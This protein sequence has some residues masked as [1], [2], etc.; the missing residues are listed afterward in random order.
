VTGLDQIHNGISRFLSDGE[1]L[2]FN[3]NEPGHGVRCYVVSVNGGKATPITPEGITGGIVSPDGKFIVANDPVTLYPLAGGAPRSIPNL[4]PGFVPLQWTEDQSS[5]YVY[6][7]G[8]VPVT[9]YKVDVLSGKQTVVRKLEPET[10]TGLVYIAPVVVTRDG[11]RFAF[12]YYHVL[13][14]LYVISGLR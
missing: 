13:S 6:R 12:S 4:Q 1:R 11:S 2:T 7:R 14:G 8:Q 3:G 9:V 10:A 5:I